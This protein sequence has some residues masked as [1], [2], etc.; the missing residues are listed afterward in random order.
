MRKLRN[1]KHILIVSLLS[2]TLIFGSIMIFSAEFS[3]AID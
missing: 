1:L 2:L 3:N